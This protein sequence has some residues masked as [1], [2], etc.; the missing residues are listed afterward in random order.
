MNDPEEVRCNR[1]RQLFLARS[2]PRIANQVLIFY[3]WL[4]QNHPELLPKKQGDPY[5]HL[6]VNLHGLYEDK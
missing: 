6:K 5:Q 3:G 4:E 2:A 1:V